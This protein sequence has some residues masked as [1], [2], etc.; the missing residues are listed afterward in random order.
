MVGVSTALSSAPSK[1]I[2]DRFRI[3]WP[4]QLDV[5]E[6]NPLFLSSAV[7]TRLNM[8]IAKRDEIAE[9]AETLRESLNLSSPVNVVGAVEMLGGEILEDESLDDEGVEALVRKHT[10]AFQI[11]LQKRKPPLRKRFSIA[12]EI[13]HLFLHMGY[14]LDPDLWIGADEYRDSVYYRYGHGI[15]EDEA[16]EFA[17]CLLMPEKEFRSLLAKHRNQMAEA[18]DALADHFQVSKDAI[19]T[20]GKRLGLLSD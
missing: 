15:E 14:L 3:W 12:H 19:C 9:L 2:V 20:R 10:D 5:A 7:W 4:L 16:N 1:F 8:T 18:T 6:A 17:A 11:V 13:G